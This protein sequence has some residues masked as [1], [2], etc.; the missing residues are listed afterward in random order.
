MPDVVDPDQTDFL[1]FICK[2]TTLFCGYS[3]FFAG[4]LAGRD[5]KTI[6]EKD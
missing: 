4:G 2:S 6:G 3:S 5:K 1:S